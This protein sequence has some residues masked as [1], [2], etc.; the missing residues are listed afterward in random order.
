M[1]E[2]FVKKLPFSQQTP[3]DKM[4]ILKIIAT[5][6][7]GSKWEYFKKI[8]NAG[9]KFEFLKEQS[10][11]DQMKATQSALKF[12][13]KNAKKL[14]WNV[15]KDSVA[16][17]KKNTGLK[18]L[19]ELPEIGDKVPPALSP[20]YDA[21]IIQWCPFKF[22]APIKQIR[23]KGIAT[24]RHSEGVV[25]KL[26]F[27][28]VAYYS[29]PENWNRKKITSYLW[30][31]T[32]EHSYQ[33]VAQYLEP[34]KKDILKFSEAY[35]P[36][37]FGKASLKA[38]ATQ[39]ADSFEDAF[40]L[41]SFQ[42]EI[43]TL[44]WYQFIYNAMEQFIFRYFVT[45][46]TSTNNLHAIRYI[47]NIFEPALA[48][49]IE[50]KNLFVGSFETDSS[51]KA[52]LA[53]FETYKAQMMALE[54]KTT[55]IKTKRTEYQSYVY[56]MPLLEKASI[57]FE[58]SRTPEKNSPW[59][60][61][62][63]QYFLGSGPKVEEPIVEGEL[64]RPLGTPHPDIDEL[65]K[66][67]FYEV[68]E[69]TAE[70]RKFALMQLL[71]SMINCHQHRLASRHKIL[72]MFKGRV[73]ADK[74]VAQKRVAKIRKEAEKVIRSM[75]RKMGKL[76]RMK[77]EKAVEAV[78]AD[79]DK[80]KQSISSKCNT[81]IEDSK[82]LLSQQKVR[83]QKLFEEI[84]KENQIPPGLASQMVMSLTKDLD[85]AKS[86]AAGDDEDAESLTKD[87]NRFITQQVIADYRKELEPLY[88]NIFQVLSPT[89]Q[90]KMM[91]AQAID[92]AGG[93]DGV[94]L[95]LDTDEMAQIDTLLNKI[96]AKINAGTPGIFDSK[97]IFLSQVIPLAD[98]FE[99]SIDNQ[100]LGQMLKLKV[101]S[102][103]SP[104]ATLIKPPTVKDLLVLNLVKNP[105]P[106]HNLVQEGR[107][108]MPDPTK[109]I[110]I[111]QLNKLLAA[112]HS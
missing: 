101:T 18:E 87:F 6:Q 96:R 41:E 75:E 53:P 57:K 85:Q 9:A 84:S 73:K 104:K 62:L 99:L 61:F 95:A 97:I 48:K 79:I 13:S 42:D 47:E 39:D 5:R 16:T 51:K 3:E 25:A 19:P 70:S 76:K 58:I 103:K 50:V 27:K 8:K 55:T 64:P 98:L 82:Y 89:T 46:I 38:D 4:K 2:L 106:A 30:K 63:Q 40:G 78:E 7:L 69:I 44:Y 59:G 71:N 34:L 54:A 22:M 74:E 68:P 80:F 105:V 93:D 43:K 66:A 23:D 67:A 91:L 77:Q 102:P 92:K 45:L 52:Y 60:R 86:A 17:I 56:N 11:M 37:K 111:S 90:E 72:E 28:V 29:T 107:E 83:L 10:L 21:V 32:P 94:K 112:S 26:L 100:S 31:I 109:V 88:A 49:S 36:F 33:E 12:S 24:Q 14:Y 20:L 108:G 65:E 15:Y 81:I 110:N 1:L 35:E